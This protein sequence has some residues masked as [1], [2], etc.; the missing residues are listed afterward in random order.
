VNVYAIGPKKIHCMHGCSGL[1]GLAIAME[2]EGPQ[3]L[4]K[5]QAGYLAII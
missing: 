4:A 2:V 3:R 1:R 5:G